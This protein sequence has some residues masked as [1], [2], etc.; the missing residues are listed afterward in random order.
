M[1]DDF[2]DLYRQIVLA[3]YGSVIVLSVIFQGG[4]AIYYFTRR[5]T[6]EAYV[7]ETPAWIRDLQSATTAI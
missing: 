6:I 5:S 4:N 3:L 2:D 7:S 1:L